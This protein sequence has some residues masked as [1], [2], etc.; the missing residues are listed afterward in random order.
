MLFICILYKWSS[1]DCS[2]DKWPHGPRHR[3]AIDSPQYPV[4]YACSGVQSPALEGIY[5]TSGF[6][7]RMCARALRAPVFLSSLPHPTGRCAPLPPSQLRCSPQNKKLFPKTK[8][9]PSGPNSGRQGHIFFHWAK[10]HPTELRC[11]LLSFAAPRWA[12]LHPRELRCTLL[13]FAAPY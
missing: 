13:S 12:T 10:L 7:P 3:S 1:P 6:W 2:W 5:K 9:L 8:C 4:R 11:T